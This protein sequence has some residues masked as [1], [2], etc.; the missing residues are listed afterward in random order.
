M[1]Y[2]RLER[3]KL[4]HN[5]LD[6]KRRRMKGRPRVKR[7]ITSA[8]KIEGMKPYGL[9]DDI[10]RN[11]SNDDEESMHDPIFLNYE[12]YE[13]IRL[14]DYENNNQ[15][16]SAAAMGVS[17]PTFTRIYMKARQKV[18]RAMVEGRI[19]M[20]GKG[21][22]AVMKDSWY[23]CESCGAIFEPQHDNILQKAELKCSLCGSLRVKKY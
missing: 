3:G 10:L 7:Y 6:L 23:E 22:N 2:V 15:E 9:S 13:S 17:R 19:L 16:M 11:E 20:I 12:E 1:V 4:N 5:E 14:C 21:A 18:A 8:P